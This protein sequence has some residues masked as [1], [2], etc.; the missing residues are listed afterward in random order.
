MLTQGNN[1]NNMSFN[2]KDVNQSWA[3][4]RKRSAGGGP[5]FITN[6]VKTYL[7]HQ[8]QMELSEEYYEVQNFPYTLAFGRETDAVKGLTFGKSFG[9]L[10][11]MESERRMQALANML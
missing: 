7:H 5:L 11:G 3:N 9:L 6:W 4:Q 2:G 10:V 8:G 1:N